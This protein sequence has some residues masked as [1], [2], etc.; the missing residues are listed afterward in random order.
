LTEIA[1]IPF[2]K[3]KENVHIFV[4]H[5][6]IPKSGFGLRFILLHSA[7]ICSLYCFIER[8]KRY[9]NYSSQQFGALYEV[10]IHHSFH[11]LSNDPLP[12]NAVKASNL[13]RSLSPSHD[14]YLILLAVYMEMHGSYRTV[15]YNQTLG[16]WEGGASHVQNQCIKGEGGGWEVSRDEN[17]LKYYFLYF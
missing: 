12:P 14:Q 10:S 11:S 3:I 9:N 8:S 17:N 1:T 13:I 6:N 4:W 16:G 15:I 5:R 2:V 7:T